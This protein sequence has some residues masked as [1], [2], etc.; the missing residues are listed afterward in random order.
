[1]L[2][3]RYVGSGILI[4]KSMQVTASKATIDD[5]PSNTSQFKS[6]VNG[7][8]V[9]LCCPNCEEPVVHFSRFRLLSKISSA[10]EKSLESKSINQLDQ[11]ELF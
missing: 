11:L 7:N 1:M 10:V 8:K 9:H 5:L 6:K 2:N 3:A 4:S